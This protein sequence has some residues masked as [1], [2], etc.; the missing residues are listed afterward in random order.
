MHQVLGPDILSAAFSRSINNSNSIKETSTFN[1]YKVIL[2]FSNYF[3]D[4]GKIFDLA[5]PKKKTKFCPLRYFI[6]L[7]HC[8]YIKNKQLTIP[9]TF[10]KPY[11]NFFLS[12]IQF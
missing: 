12:M 10:L 5:K 11:N 3:F 2:E 7:K 9:K 6:L 4:K 8:I 1:S